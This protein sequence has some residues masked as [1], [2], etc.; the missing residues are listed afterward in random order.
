MSA[1]GGMVFWGGAVSCKD[2]LSVKLSHLTYMIL[3][4]RFYVVLGF[5]NVEAV[6]I[7]RFTQD[8]IYS[9]RGAA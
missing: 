8:L 2:I 9:T 3:N 6:A 1:M 4:T 7:V 5:T